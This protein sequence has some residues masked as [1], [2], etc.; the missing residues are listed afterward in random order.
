MK[1]PEWVGGVHG[2]EEGGNIEWLMT[3]LK[4][5]IAAMIELDRSLD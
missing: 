5:Y 4:I 1:A 3:A 2:P